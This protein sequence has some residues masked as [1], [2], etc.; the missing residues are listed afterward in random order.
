MCKHRKLQLVCTP[1]KLSF[2][3]K[4]KNRQNKSL[5]TWATWTI[6][7]IKTNPN[8]PETTL[9]QKIQSIRI[10]AHNK[11]IRPDFDKYLSDSN[12]RV[13]HEAVIA[14]RQCKEKKFTDHLKKLAKEE[15]EQTKRCN[16]ITL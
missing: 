8:L 9:N 5:E 12:A 3:S 14:I 1:N 15:K 16:K 13:R 10:Q 7:R 6:G 11:K 4:Y 2:S